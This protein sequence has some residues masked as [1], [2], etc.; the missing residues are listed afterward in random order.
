MELIDLPVN[1]DTETAC[2]VLISC[3]APSESGEMKVELTYQGDPLLA[4]YLIQSAQD[5]LD[6]HDEC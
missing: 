3:G 6:Q 2:Y 5:V 4:S 1:L